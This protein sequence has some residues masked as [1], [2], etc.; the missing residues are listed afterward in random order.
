M[1]P[2]TLVWQ[3]VFMLFSGFACCLPGS[4]CSGRTFFPFVGA[5]VCVWF[6]CPCVCVCCVCCGSVVWP[7][8]ISRNP[9][10][11]VIVR[12]FIQLL[13]FPYDSCLAQISAP[14]STNIAPQK[15]LEL[16]KSFFRKND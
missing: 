14:R 15:I 10:I 12:I 5:V 9:N 16:G 7:N 2:F 8:A 4:A 3:R 13:P 1:R 6:V 11:T